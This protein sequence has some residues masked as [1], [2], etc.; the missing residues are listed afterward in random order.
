MKRFIATF[1]L[2]LTFAFAPSVF[3]DDV[4]LPASGDLWD[5]YNANQDFY[6]Q[7]KKGVSDE[8]FDKAIEQ[9]KD[10][11]NRNIF[12]RKKKNKNIPKGEEFSQSNESEFIDVQVDKD[13]LPVVSLPVELVVG[14]GVLP[15]GH[16]QIQGERKDDKVYL[17]FYQ[18]HNLFAT[19]PAIE[20]QDDFGEEEIL[21]A[22]WFSEGDKQIK[23]IFGSL[24]FNAYT[25]VEIKE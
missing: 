18:A 3:A 23:I 1:V 16:Y 12:G 25:F 2:L 20:T 15:V 7:D 19:I 6:G 14:N 10:K 8:A 17:K 21:F 4:D 11:Q 9:V 13:A 24:D 22:R 5:S